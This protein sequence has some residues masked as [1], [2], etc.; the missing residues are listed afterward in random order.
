MAFYSSDNLSTL[1]AVQKEL[2]TRLV[3]DGQTESLVDRLLAPR[4]KSGREI[5]AEAITGQLRASAGTLHQSAQNALEG[6]SIAASLH[7]TGQGVMQALTTMRDIAAN[8]SSSWTP[9]QKTAAENAYKGAAAD[10]ANL[11]KTTSYNGMSLLDGT[12]WAADERTQ[13]GKIQIRMGGM[14]KDIILTDW[15]DW[16]ST[17]SGLSTPS[18]LPTWDDVTD[19]ATLADSLFRLNQALGTARIQDLS[20]QALEASFTSSAEVLQ[21]R[22][23]IF[24]EAAARAI[25]GAREDPV[26]RL[27][28]TLLTDQG[29]I[30]DSLS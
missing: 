17:S 15:S 26:G 5:A 27:L 12:K 1:L 22:A 16:T 7:T 21:D 10:I 25:L 29:K 18:A 3:T 9:E 20:W 30:L 6:Q 13:S 19:S 14:D 2:I 24:S 23:G 28:Y 4:Q 11:I 8:Y